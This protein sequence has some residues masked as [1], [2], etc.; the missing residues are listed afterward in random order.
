MDNGVGGQ[1]EWRTRWVNRS[2]RCCG[3]ISTVASS[4]NSMVPRS[5][6]TPGYWPIGK[7]CGGL[8]N[9]DEDPLRRKPGKSTARRKRQRGE[10]D[11]RDM[12]E[13]RKIWTNG[14]PNEGRSPISCYGMAAEGMQF[15]WPW[16]D[17]TI[18]ANL[19]GIWEMSGEQRSAQRA[20]P[21]I[22]SLF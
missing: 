16:N 3:S 8:M 2:R 12:S 7:S 22:Q 21:G 15:P 9:C 4:L 11:R 19:R 14:F 6:L 1:N 5:P 17:G 13:W 20:H 18:S 10:S